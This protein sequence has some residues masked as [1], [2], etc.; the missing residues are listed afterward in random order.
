MI[1]TVLAALATRPKM[2]HGCRTGPLRPLC[3]RARLWTF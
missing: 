3:Q 1:V 2:T